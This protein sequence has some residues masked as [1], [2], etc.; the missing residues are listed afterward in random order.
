M[1]LEYYTN[2]MSRGVISHWMLEEVG[3][4]YQT[5]W[6]AWGP[7]G[8]KS[9]EYLKINPMGKVPTLIHDGHI[10]TEAAAIC[11]YLA[12]VF[13][14]ANLKPGPEGLADY[15]RWTFFC[16]G[17]IEQAVTCKAMGWQVAPE[18]KGTLGFGDFED[19]IGALEGALKGRDFVCGKQFTAADVYVG[20]SV[21]WGLS[22]GTM[23]KLP[24]FVAY[25]DRVEAR[26][27]YQRVSEICKAK[28]AELNAGR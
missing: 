16:A 24:A 20:S 14:Q 11:L 2:P 5:T 27:A 23:P 18:R 9:A 7:T 10:V 4:P 19:A 26:P 28:A 3:Q 6:L 1:A 25:R 12:E 8:H 13:P 21:G 22:F 17:P 15:Y